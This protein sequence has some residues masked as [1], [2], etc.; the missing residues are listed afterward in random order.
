MRFFKSTLLVASLGICTA[1]STLT[2]Y[3]RQSSYTD[4]NTFKAYGVN[5]GGWL[6]QESTID[7]TWWATYSGGATD[8]WGLCENLGSKCGS[9]LESRYATWITTADIDKAADSGVT[10]LRIPKTYAAWINFPGSKLYSG[11]QTTYLKQIS[12]YAIKEYGMHIVVDL[13]SLPGGVNG[14][15]IGEAN[16][17]WSWFNNQTNFDYSMEAVDAVLSFIQNSEYPE[18]FTFEPLNEA[19]DNEDLSVFGSAAGLTSSGAKWVLKYYN[20]VLDR[21]TAVND[22]IPVMFQDCFQ[23]ETF[24]SGNFSSTANIAFDVHEYFFGVENATSENEPSLIFSDAKSSVGD[25]KFP[26][27]VGEWSIEALNSNS[28]ALRE[29]NFNFGL[30]A[31]HNYTQGEAYWTWKFLGNTTVD[32]QGTQAD[33]WNYEYFV[34]Q[35]YFHP[36]SASSFC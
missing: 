32:G 30:A 5:L 10:L 28:L 31:F 15:P 14:L 8:E 20:A 3:T 24:W 17:H 19:A 33:Y 27:F 21:V 35:G 1:T 6:V 36:E 7:T 12:T 25:G 4:W 26:V 29:Q 11:N 23:G 16:D 18:Y 34:D 9:V 2:R 22:Q 13:H